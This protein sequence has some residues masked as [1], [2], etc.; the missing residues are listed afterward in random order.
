[1]ASEQRWRIQQAFERG[2][3]LTDDDISFLL[4]EIQRLHD[5]NETNSRYWKT[6]LNNI[7][8]KYIKSLSETKDQ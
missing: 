5:E 7:S 6:Q 2:E 3:R 8:E 4:C 1:M